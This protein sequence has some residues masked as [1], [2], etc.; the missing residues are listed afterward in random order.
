MVGRDEG[1]GTVVRFTLWERVAH[2]NHAVTFLVLLVTGMVLVVRGAAGLLGAPALRALGQVHHWAAIPFTFVT[3]PVLW[4]GARKQTREWIRECFRF[5]R[6]DRLFLRR[7]AREFFG[8]GA[9]LPPQGKFNAGEK[10]N[11]LMQILGW[12]VMV[13]T[14]WLLYFRDAL[15]RDV[16]AWALAIHSTTAMVLGAAVIGHMYLALLH[17]HT[18]QGLSGM[19]S[20]RVPAAWAQDHHPKWYGRMAGDPAGAAEE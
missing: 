7:F 12:P 6:D 8:L 16:G 11:S 9:D 1:A 14:G 10:V 15:P 5:D 19:L 17:P 4:L 2:W 3:V 20:G 13:T 18:R